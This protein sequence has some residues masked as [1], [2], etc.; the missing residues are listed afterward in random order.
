[1]KKLMFLLAMALILAISLGGA[2]SATALDLGFG[3]IDEGAF[4][5]GIP[6]GEQ[7]TSSTVLGEG[8]WYYDG[9]VGVWN[10]ASRDTLAYVD[11]GGGFLTRFVDDIEEDH[12]Y[13]LSLDV[14][15]LQPV[16]GKHWDVKLLAWNLNTGQQAPL[17]HEF[18]TTSAGNFSEVNLSWT[19]DDYIGW[20]I[21]VCLYGSGSQ[22][23]FDKV[24]VQNDTPASILEPAAD[25]PAPVPEP[26]TML[27][28]GSGLVAL[29]SVRRRFIKK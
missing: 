16:S 22:V 13:S 20:E 10:P 19:A 24:V 21:A 15:T 12:I 11:I 9:N 17:G 5:P 27:L 28:L 3:T 29:V 4:A 8:G 25:T 7:Y 2:A 14:G 1:M 23:N 6:E 26:A 18:G